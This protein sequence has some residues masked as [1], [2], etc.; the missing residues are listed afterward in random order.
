[1]SLT[2]PMTC[3]RRGCANP[4]RQSGGVGR[5]TCGP[6]C[7]RAL[8]RERAREAN[9]TELDRLRM[10]AARP[11]FDDELPP[12]ADALDASLGLDP[13]CTGCESSRVPGGGLCPRCLADEER[14]P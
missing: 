10:A 2:G 6:A 11:R 5:E 12:S 8:S 7:Q 4:I 1:M 3:A 14:G 13:W 9:P